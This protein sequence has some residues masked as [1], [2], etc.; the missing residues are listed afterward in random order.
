M[1]QVVFWQSVI[2]GGKHLA[3]KPI[4]SVIPWIATGPNP[5]EWFKMG[6]MVDPLTAIMLFFVSITC[7]CI[8]VYSTGYHNAGTP[9]SKHNK[10]GEPPEVGTMRMYSRFAYISLFA[11]AMLVLVWPDNILL[12]FVSWE[13]MGSCRSADRLWFS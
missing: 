12:M 9:E 4:H 11:A 7:L 5:E 8:F 3:E 1:A 2:E 13:V 10:K 6:V